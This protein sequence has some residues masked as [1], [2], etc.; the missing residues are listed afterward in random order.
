MANTIETQILLPFEETQLRDEY[1]RYYVCKRTNYFTTIHSFPMLWDSYVRL[2]E[3]CTRGF[4][5]LQRI[6]QPGQMLPL[7]L[8][9]NA[10]AQF[11]V[12]FELGF[13][14]CIGRAWKILRSS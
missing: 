13:S 14:T 11:R 4:S 2:D 1:R 12:A 6:T 9:M 8:F 10:H 3:I 7:T 5:D